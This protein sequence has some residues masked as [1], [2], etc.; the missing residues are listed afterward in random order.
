MKFALALLLLLATPV[1]AQ[2]SALKGHN[3]DAPIDVDAAR[4]EVRDADKQAVFSGDVKVKQ[5]D[6][7]LAADTVK[8]SYSNSGGPN[9]AIQRLDA[10][11]N[12]VVTS[13]SE[14]AIGR[15]GIYD[16]VAKII[17][18]LGD[19]VL[20]RGDS[21]LNGQRLTIDLNTGRSNLDGRLSAGTAGS[22]VAGSGR[23]TG[24]FV[25]PQKGAKP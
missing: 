8:V 17:T 9:P 15:T 24:R 22:T 11:G 7:N 18:L 6:L 25:V 21:R 3:T 14:R 16:T 1:V 20:V 10:R 4:I 12:V 19:V 2:T 13:P 5:G 23:V